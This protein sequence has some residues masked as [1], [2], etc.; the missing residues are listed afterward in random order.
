MFLLPFFHNTVVIFFCFRA[1]QYFQPCDHIL[2]KSWRCHIIG[3]YF[4]ESR[5]I[6]LHAYT[7]RTEKRF[8]ALM[9]YFIP[10]LC[11]KHLIQLPALLCLF[12]VGADLLKHV[13]RHWRRKPIII[14]HLTDRLSFLLVVSI[15]SMCVSSP[16]Y[17]GLQLLPEHKTNSDLRLTRAV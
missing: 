4:L 16:E 8:F 1:S 13:L 5:F 3:E 2:R 15:L 17:S 11:L 10:A 7:E 9:G 6:Q 14:M 12:H